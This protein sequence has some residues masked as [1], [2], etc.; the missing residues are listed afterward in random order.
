MLLRLERRPVVSSNL[1]PLSGGASD[2]WP[3]SPKPV[4]RSRFQMPLL[5]FGLEAPPYQVGSHVEHL[6]GA[7][8]LGPY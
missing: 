3:G 6:S 7:H 5:T 2:E 8:Q 1:A 4:L